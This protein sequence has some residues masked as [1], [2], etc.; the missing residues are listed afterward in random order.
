[1]NISLVCHF[2]TVSVLGAKFFWGFLHPRA[3]QGIEI[4]SIYLWSICTPCMWFESEV[5]L[6]CILQC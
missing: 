6:F 3:V 2:R 1:M 4:V 5:M